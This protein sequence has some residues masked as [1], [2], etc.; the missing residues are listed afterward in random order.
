MKKLNDEELNQVIGGNNIV[1]NDTVGTGG[2][3]LT[4]I[5]EKQIKAATDTCT[6]S[7]RASVQQ[8]ITPLI[9]QIDENALINK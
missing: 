2:A 7:D 9:Q 1:G 3:S 5:K 8:E 6:A 4:S